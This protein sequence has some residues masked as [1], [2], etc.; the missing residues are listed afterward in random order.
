MRRRKVYKEQDHTEVSCR[1]CTE[2][3]KDRKE[4]D[5]RL[6]VCKEL[7]RRFLLRREVRQQVGRLVLWQGQCQGR[8]WLEGEHSGCGVGTWD[9][10]NTL[11]LRSIW[12]Q[13]RWHLLG[14]GGRGWGGWVLGMPEMK[15]RMNEWINDLFNQ[16]VFGMTNWYLLD[17]G[18]KK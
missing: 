2:S 7:L 15:N 5:C 6:E 14:L 4:L 1:N 10:R 3:R 18:S 12:G 13:R 17:I 9:L 8:R 16:S 11:D